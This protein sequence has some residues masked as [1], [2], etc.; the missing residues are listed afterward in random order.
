MAV[1]SLDTYHLVDM[2]M[3]NQGMPLLLL[4]YIRLGEHI[5]HFED[6]VYDLDIF[7]VVLYLDYIL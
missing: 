1:R 7:G 4:A 2:S 3:E 6:M 5:Y